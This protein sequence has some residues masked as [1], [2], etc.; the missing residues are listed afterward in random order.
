[1]TLFSRD[2]GGG[3]VLTM[4]F[5]ILKDYFYKFYFWIGLLFS[6]VSSIYFYIVVKTLQDDIEILQ[7]QIKTLLPKQEKIK[8]V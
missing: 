2:S 5:K 4:N 6:I 7:T 3:G 1:M 8:N